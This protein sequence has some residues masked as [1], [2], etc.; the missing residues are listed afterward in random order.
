MRVLFLY[1]WGNFYPATAGADFVACNQLTYLQSRNF[2]VH[3]VL[4]KVFSRGAGDLVKLMQRFPCIKSTHV[5]EVTARAL[6]L[7]DLLFGFNRAANSTQFR[8]LAQQQFDLFFANYVLSAPFACA[9]PREL[10]KIVETIDLL[11]G[12][13]RT[14]NLLSQASPPPASIQLA[15]ER[16]LLEQLE[17]DLYRAFDRAMMISVKEAEAIRVLGYRSAEYV[18]QPFP[19]TFPTAEC[20]R[21]HEYD[22]VFVGSENHLNTRGIHWFYRH[23]YLPF[24]RR[25]RVSLAVAGRVCD[26]LDFE[27]ALVK[28]LGFMDELHGLYE[29]SK[30]VVVPIF[31]GTGTAIKLHEALAAGKAVVSTPVGCRGIDPSSRALAC[32]DMQDRPRQTAEIILNLLRDDEERRAMQSRAIDLM[33]KRHSPSVYEQTMDHLIEVAMRRRRKPAA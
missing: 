22:L 25:H 19:L 24:L 13:F 5:I 1:P 3:C 14:T 11:A 9:L 26:N 20:S 18:A 31:E 15:E 2:E 8:T 4:L 28:K 7:R 12:L 16:F 23:V 6:T 10:C 21:P 17:V 32:I 30:L 29:A 27:D 33:R